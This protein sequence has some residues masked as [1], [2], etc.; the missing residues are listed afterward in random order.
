MAKRPAKKPSKKDPKKEQ[1]ARLKRVKQSVATSLGSV[2]YLLLG[3]AGKVGKHEARFL[4]VAKANLE[5]VFQEIQEMTD[6]MED[7]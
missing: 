4:K 5:H 3:G 1:K 2:N 6:G 7:N